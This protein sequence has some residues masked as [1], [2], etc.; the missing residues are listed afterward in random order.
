MNPLDFLAQQNMPPGG[1]P[2][3]GME[4]DA[5]LD[6]LLTMQGLDPSIMAQLN[7][8]YPAEGM[9]GQQLTQQIL[10]APAPAITPDDVNAI[11]QALGLNKVDTNTAYQ[12]DPM[13][14]QRFDVM[15]MLGGYGQ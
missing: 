1:T 10:G 13:F 3:Y 5:E 9:T 7:T 12:S 6:P 15:R 4:S 14:S 2:T 8:Q 11:A